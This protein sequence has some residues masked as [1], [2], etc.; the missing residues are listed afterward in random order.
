ML[1]NAAR[2]LEQKFFDDGKERAEMLRKKKEPIWSG[3]VSYRAIIPSEKLREINPGHRAFASI[4]AVSTILNMATGWMTIRP[5][6]YRT[7]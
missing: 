2:E 3:I 6:V 7:R 4:N 5:K 1:E